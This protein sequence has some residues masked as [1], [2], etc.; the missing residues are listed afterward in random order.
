MR[1][2]QTR[3]ARIEAITG[4]NSSR[5]IIIDNIG[6]DSIEAIPAAELSSIA[7]RLAAKSR[8]PV[9]IL[10]ADAILRAWEVNHEKA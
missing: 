1:N 2:L 6:Y 5:K 10:T 3:L 8:Y 7:R 4:L 9:A